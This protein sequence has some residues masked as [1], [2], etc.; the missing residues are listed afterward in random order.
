M[1]LTPVSEAGFPTLRTAATF[2]RYYYGICQLNS[3]HGAVCRLIAAPIAVAT[4][5]ARR[6]TFRRRF[7]ERLANNLPAAPPVDLGSRPPLEAG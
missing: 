6:Q 4:Y 3:Y 2:V 1:L 7:P 5:S